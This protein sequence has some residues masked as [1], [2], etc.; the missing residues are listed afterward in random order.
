MRRAT[1]HGHV[2][3]S[4]RCACPRG[5]GLC[6]CACGRGGGGGSARS[7]PAPAGTRPC[8]S[9]GMLVQVEVE[10]LDAD[11]NGA[12]IGNIIADKQDLAGSC[13]LHALRNCS[14]TFPDLSARTR[15]LTCLLAHVP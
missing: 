6:V 10:I 5:C 12:F 14:H 15:S 3:F 4:A 8:P 9:A 7:T 11:R 2:C 13:C 1:L